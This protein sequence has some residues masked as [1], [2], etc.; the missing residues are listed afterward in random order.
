M[1]YYKGI[2]R[3]L[4]AQGWENVVHKR[5]DLTP[6]AMREYRRV[7]VKR[8]VARL[9]LSEYEECTC[10]LDEREYQ[11]PRVTIPLKQHIGAP[12]RPVVKTG[13][14]VQCGDLIARIPEGKLGA[15]VHASI[16]GRV[17]VVT[18]EHVV[19]AA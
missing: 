7:P 2:K 19:I 14:R 12:S 8:L 18:G 13:D 5:S 3:Q 17:E 4:A 11:P 10:P 16:S 1:A 6:H 15:N 9:G